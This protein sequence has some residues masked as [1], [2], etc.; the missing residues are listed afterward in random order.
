MVCS[1][2]VHNV[3]V[4]WFRLYLEQKKYVAIA[5]SAGLFMAFSLRMGFEKKIFWE[6]GLP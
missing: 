1:Y 5:S 2:F 3:P 4:F 6:R